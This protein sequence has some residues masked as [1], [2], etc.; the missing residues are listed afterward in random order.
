MERVLVGY[1]SMTGMTER[2][3]QYIAEG[4]RMSG[5]EPTVR[6]I[7][8]IE[9]ADDLVGYDGYVFGSPT[10]FRDIPEPMKGFLTMARNADLRGKLAGAFGSYTHDGNAPAII[11]DT[12]EHVFEMEP[13]RLGPLNLK[14]LMLEK[15][16]RDEQQRSQYVAGEVIEQGDQG[17]RACQDYGRA[18][19]EALG[20]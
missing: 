1:F 11:L 8:D 20:A 7:S 2:M 10:H 3:A 14:E 18:F 9:K 19:G 15:P 13:F 16:G 17:M 12:L 6:K 4:I 5:E